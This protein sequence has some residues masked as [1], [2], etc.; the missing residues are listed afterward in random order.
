MAAKNCGII[1]PREISGYQQIRGAMSWGRGR[2]AEKKCGRCA[3]RF[4]NGAKRD[5]DAMW[6]WCK[7]EMKADEPEV[8]GDARRGRAG[9]M[10]EGTRRWTEFFFKKLIN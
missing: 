6:A 4:V 2:G 7:A 1:F 8:W 9:W 10:R 5:W 3:R